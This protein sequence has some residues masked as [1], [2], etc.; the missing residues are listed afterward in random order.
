MK[1]T[2]PIIKISIFW[3]PVR[4]QRSYR[5]TGF[6][7]VN[8]VIF[9]LNAFIFYMNSQHSKGKF[10]YWPQ[11]CGYLLLYSTAMMYHIVWACTLARLCWRHLSGNGCLHFLCTVLCYLT[12]ERKDIRTFTHFAQSKLRKTHKKLLFWLESMTCRL[13]KVVCGRLLMKLKIA[14]IFP[15]S[16]QVQ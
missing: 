15:K 3:S 5:T 7:Y 1:R 10:P 4:L 11:I 6:I 12:Y 16:A 13:L 14:Q 2:L 9:M 8:F